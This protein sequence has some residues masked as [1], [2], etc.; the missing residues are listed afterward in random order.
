MCR[1]AALACT[2]EGDCG[3][4]LKTIS[5]GNSASLPGLYR[6]GLR[7]RVNDLRLGEAILLGRDPVTRTPIKGLSTDAFVLV[8]EIIESATDTPHPSVLRLSVTDTGKSKSLLALGDQDTDIGGLSMPDGMT[9]LG[10]SSDHLLLQTRGVAL[11]AGSE[12]CFQP[13]YSALMRAMSAPDVEKIILGGACA[14][15]AAPTQD[16]HPTLAQA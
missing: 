8:A 7:T 6:T 10:S 5:G 12:V 9:W 14:H 3:V 2:L 4:T 15:G 11:M 1:L 16:R 13:D